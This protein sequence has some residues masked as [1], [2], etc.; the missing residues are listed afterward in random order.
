M[1][2]PPRSALAAMLVVL[3]LGTLGLFLRDG[4]GSATLLARFGP[5]LW[6]AVLG[7]VVIAALAALAAWLH[8]RSHRGPSGRKR[9]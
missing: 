6:Q 4:S 7:L 2:R 8:E 1:S 5:L 9:H 3:L